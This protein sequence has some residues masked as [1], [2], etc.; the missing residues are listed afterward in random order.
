MVCTFSPRADKDL[1][2]LSPDVKERIVEKI[3][4]LCANDLMVA[5]SIQ[6]TG[7]LGGYL[8]IRIG[9]Y[10]VIFDV[11]DRAEAYILRIGHRSVIYD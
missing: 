2:K 1:T 3:Q 8:R 4:Y 6:L 7:R 9:D 5:S 10:R 11:K